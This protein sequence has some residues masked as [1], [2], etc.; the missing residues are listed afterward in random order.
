MTELHRLYD[1]QGQSPWLDNLTRTYLRDGTLARFVANG[2]RGVTTNPTIFAKAIGGSD[3]CDEQFA[4]LADAGTIIRDSYWELAIDDVRDALAV[5]RPTFDASRGTDGFV[6]IEV[7]PE[8]ARDTEGTV[9]AVRDLH[10]RID[11]PNLFVK[12][13][14]T[15][16]GIP[17][18]QAM[19]AEGRNVNI[20][21]IFSLS[22]YEQVI[23]A[24]LSGLE[25]FTSAGG[26]PAAA[27]RGIVLRQSSRH[28]SRPT[29]RSHRYDRGARAAGPC[30]RRSSAT[31]L[32]TV[33]RPVCRRSV[34]G[35]R[36]TRSPPA[37]PAMGVDVDQEPRVL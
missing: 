11:Q 15:P 22:R 32:P 33:P 2:I 27:Q 21:L 31:R 25:S 35:T 29:P 19:T 7:A 5:L 13:P 24:Y 23:D 28:R 9:V 20:T 18:I 37:T 17:A 36:D 30:R 1:E 3:A 12:I 10:Q 16:E 6:S 14:A 26:N 4:T 34:E 8:L